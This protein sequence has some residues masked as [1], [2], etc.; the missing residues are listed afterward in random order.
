L[1]LGRLPS[2][3]WFRLPVLLYLDDLLDGV[4]Y[5]IQ[6]NLTA[7]AETLLADKGFIETPFASMV[8]VTPL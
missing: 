8:A 2:A 4:T 7:T 6:I 3:D 1:G 5:G